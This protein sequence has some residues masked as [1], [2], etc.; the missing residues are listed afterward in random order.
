MSELL[1]Y[2]KD[3][4]IEINAL[5]LEWIRHPSKY[6][7]YAELSAKADDEVRRKKHNLE[8]TDAIIDKEIRV[9]SEGTKEKLTADAIKNKI[10]SDSRHIE[11]LMDYNDSLYQADICS[12]AVKAMDHKKNA[13]QA[14]VQLWAGS[15]FAGPKVPRDLKDISKIEEDGI[16]VEKNHVREMMKRRERKSKNEEVN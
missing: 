11:A 12:S 15:Y 7:H 4:A 5:D 8:V 14:C 10:I 2:Q 9:Q 16:E 3:V 6:M 1:N 13:L